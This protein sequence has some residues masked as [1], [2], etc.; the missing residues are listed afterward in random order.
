MKI[1]AAILE[2]NAGPI[3]LGGVIRRAPDKSVPATFAAAAGSHKAGR[4]VAH[5]SQWPQLG[6]NTRTT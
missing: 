3:R 5:G 4:P 6:T 1:R 2:E